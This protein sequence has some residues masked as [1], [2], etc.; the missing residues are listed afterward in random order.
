MREGYQ[1][2][3]QTI[4]TQL[5]HGETRDENAI[6]KPKL[7]HKRCRR[8]YLKK[9]WRKH[10]DIMNNE[11]QINLPGNAS[12]KPK[13]ARLPLNFLCSSFL[14]TLLLCNSNPQKSLKISPLSPAK[15]QPP[16]AK[17]L[18]WQQPKTLLHNGLKILMPRVNAD[19]LQKRTLPIH[20][21]MHVLPKIK[22]GCHECS[23]KCPYI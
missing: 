4:K 22:K 2:L 5:D 7:T 16:S 1:T 8:N 3:N 11:L 21:L 15:K 12:L 17:A 18:P 19:C 10:D 20:P 6:T 23:L 14:L 9:R 13:F